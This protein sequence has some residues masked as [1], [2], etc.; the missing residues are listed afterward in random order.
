MR[1][2]WEVSASS[3]SR[4]AL[5]CVESPR[6]LAPLFPLFC[7]S[8]ASALAALLT[9]AIIHLPVLGLRGDDLARWSTN[10][11]HWVLNNRNAGN[12]NR[13]N[14]RK[15]GNGNRLDPA[16][17]T[18]EARLLSRGNSVSMARMFQSNATYQS[19]EPGGVRAE[20]ET[21]RIVLNVGVERVQL[22]ANG[23]TVFDIDRNESVLDGEL[24]TDS[25]RGSCF[26]SAYAIEGTPQADCLTLA[27]ETSGQARPLV[28]SNPV[29]MNSKDVVVPT[30]VSWP[31]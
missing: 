29:T 30:Y 13:P 31:L 16:V 21:L 7:H 11:P 19:A 22:F 27:P 10:E 25:T 4:D 9:P 6:C 26:S 28:L 1:E 3:V 20:N 12:G 2:P 15:S 5:L 14:N 18:A 23:T 8:T 24:L 17:S